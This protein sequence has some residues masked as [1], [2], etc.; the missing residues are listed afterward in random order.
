MK[1]FSLFSRKVIPS[2]LISIL[3]LAGCSEPEPEEPDTDRRKSPIAIAQKTHEPSNTY[4]KI[5]YGQPYKKDRQI[6][7]ELVPYNQVWRTGANEATELT[8]TKEISFAGKSLDA[9]TYALFT[10]PREDNEW[11][12]ILNNE[13]GQWGAFEYDSTLDVLRVDVPSQST[14]KVTEAFTIRFSEIQEDSTN[15]IIE[16]DQV[17]LNI[18]VNFL[19]SNSPT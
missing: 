9:G 12:I 16:W 7:G 4:I 6:F 14:K 1:L 10:I 15:I 13:L 5:V 18:P 19:N 8:T 2:V 17:E 3:L 11:T